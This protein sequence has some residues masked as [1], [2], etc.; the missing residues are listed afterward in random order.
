MVA[1]PGVAPVTVPEDIPTVTTDVLPLLQVPPVV[2][3]S[4]VVVSPAHTV[5]VPEIT[6]GNEFT[7]MP[8]VTVQP[9]G[10]VYVT[11]AVPGVTPVTTPVAGAMVATVVLLLDQVP[12]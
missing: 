10:R 5:S 3:F 7:V 12:P 1:V 9:V 2:V 4:N 8:L 11:E 6:D